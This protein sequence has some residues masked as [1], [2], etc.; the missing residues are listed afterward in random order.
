MD[1]RRSLYTRSEWSQPIINSL[2]FEHLGFCLLKIGVWMI[3][4]EVQDFSREYPEVS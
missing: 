2:F 4:L 1:T 3:G